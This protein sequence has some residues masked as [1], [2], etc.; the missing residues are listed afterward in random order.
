MFSHTRILLHCGGVQIPKP[1]KTESFGFFGFGICT[2]PQCKSI[3]V[4][5]NTKAESINYRHSVSVRNWVLEIENWTESNRI[6][7][8]QTN[9]ALLSTCNSPINSLTEEYFLKI[10]HDFD[11]NWTFYILS[12]SSRLELRCARPGNSNG[13]ISVLYDA[14]FTWL[15]VLLV[16]HVLCISIW[17]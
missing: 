15:G 8:I 9:P 12:C 13:H 1:K 2:P 4:C 7:K 16:L 14:T 5:E 10:L 11:L 6:R 3:L 17:P